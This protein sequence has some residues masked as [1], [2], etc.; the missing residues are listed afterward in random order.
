MT[1]DAVIPDLGLPT[2]MSPL[3]GGPGVGGE[4]LCASRLCLGPLKQEAP[5]GRRLPRRG[6]DHVRPVRHLCRP[7]E[8]GLSMIL[9]IIYIAATVGV[10]IYMLWA[11]L[12]PEKF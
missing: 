5:H 1:F 10:A 2:F 9:D 7:S 11:L 4:P 6:R 3:C 12:A 8:E